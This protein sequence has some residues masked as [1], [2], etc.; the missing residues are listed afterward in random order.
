MLMGLI[1]LAVMLVEGGGIFVAMKLFGS[2]PAPAIGAGLIEPQA[3]QLP[4]QEVLIARL[5]APNTKTGKL[6]LYD[7]E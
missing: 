1:I 5:K 6:F 7:I 4:D 3:E 2:R